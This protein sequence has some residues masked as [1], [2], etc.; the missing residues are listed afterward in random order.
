VVE[1]ASELGELAGP[2][3]RRAGREV[4]GSELRRGRPQAVEPARDRR[5]EREPD[6]DRPRGRAGGDLEDLQV[7]AHVEHDPAGHQDGGERDHDREQGEAGELQAHGGQQQEKQRSCERRGQR[8]RGDGEAE[9]G[10][11]TNR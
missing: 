10:H 5:A 8:R 3:V 6:G 11:G 2:V 1:R 9:P 4:A 7:V